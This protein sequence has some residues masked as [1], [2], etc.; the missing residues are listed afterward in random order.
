MQHALGAFEGVADAE[1]EFGHGGAA[2]QVGGEA[3]GDGIKDFDEFGDHLGGP[4]GGIGGGDEFALLGVEPELTALDFDLEELALQ[5]VLIVGGGVLR[6]ACCVLRVEPGEEFE[7]IDAAAAKARGA[8]ALGF[9]QDGF[10]EVEAGGGGGDGVVGELGFAFRL[11]ADGFEF[12]LGELLATLALGGDALKALGVGAEEIV[13]LVGG[14]S[15]ALQVDEWDSC[16]S[17]KW[18]KEFQPIFEGKGLCVRRRW[19]IVSASITL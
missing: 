9:L 18:V 5:C 3:A 1:F 19:H 4:L 6:I 7:G 12:G 8:V 17:E 2:G 15:E 13:G 11:P 10:V 16:W 14:H